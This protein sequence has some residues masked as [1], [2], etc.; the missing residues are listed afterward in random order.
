MRNA[1]FQ[2]G[3]LMAV[4]AAAIHASVPAPAAGAAFWTF[5]FLQLM[6]GAMLTW[7]RTRLPLSTASMSIAAAASLVMAALSGRGITF[8]NMP[9]GWMI[10]FAAVAVTL[11]LLLTIEARRYP[12]PTAAWRDFMKGKNGLDVFTGDHIP[13]LRG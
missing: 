5:L 6:Q 2:Y 1:G 8:E 4:A 12:I 10:A 3:L 7:R 11:P 9:L 13:H